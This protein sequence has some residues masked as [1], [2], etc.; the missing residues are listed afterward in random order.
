MGGQNFKY[1]LNNG[2][3]NKSH[4]FLRPRVRIYVRAMRSNLFAKINELEKKTGK[5]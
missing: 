2:F 3:K 1:I 5:K 4:S